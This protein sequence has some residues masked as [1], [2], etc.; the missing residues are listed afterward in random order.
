MRLWR[1]REKSYS[2]GVSLDALSTVFE[3]LQSIFPPPM[4][5]CQGREIVSTLPLIYGRQA[6]YRLLNHSLLALRL[7]HVTGPANRRSG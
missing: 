1:V 5:S 7:H 4:I 3:C 2:V 6:T